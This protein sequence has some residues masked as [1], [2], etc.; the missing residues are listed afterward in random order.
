MFHIFDDRERKKNISIMKKYDTL[1]K[2]NNTIYYDKSLICHFDTLFKNIKPKQEL[3]HKDR[4][5]NLSII[6]RLWAH[7]VQGKS[8]EVTRVIFIYKSPVFR[9]EN[10]MRHIEQCLDTTPYHVIFIIIFRDSQ[11][12][13]NHVIERINLRF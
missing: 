12:T 3:L 1:Y 2:F 13:G 11:N 5:T 4:H 10:W 9:I 7:K 8:T 6:V